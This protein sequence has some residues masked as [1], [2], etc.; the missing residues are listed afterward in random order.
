MPL[1]DPKTEEHRRRPR[2]RTFSSGAEGRAVVYRGENIEPMLAAK[3]RERGV[4]VIE[5]VHVTNPL[6]QQDTGALAINNEPDVFDHAR[7]VILSPH[8]IANCVS[9]PHQMFPTVQQ[10]GLGCERHSE[11]HSGEAAINGDGDPCDEGGLVTGQKDFQPAHL[12]GLTETAHRR[13]GLFHGPCSLWVIQ[14][15]LD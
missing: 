14:G 8:D 10:I 11:S 9:Q 12:D 13:T 5:K 3:A 2:H 6:Q 15:F 4:E 1:R 7:L